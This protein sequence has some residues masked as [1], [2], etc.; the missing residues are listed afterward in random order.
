MGLAAW[1]PMMR[2]SK[3]ISLILSLILIMTALLLAACASGTSLPAASSAAPSPSVE[4]SPTAVPSVPA[5]TATTQNP[6]APTVAARATHPLAAMSLDGL[7]FQPGDLPDDVRAG[8]LDR[9]LPDWMRKL[10]KIDAAAGVALTRSGI[11]SDYG[12]AQLLFDTHPSRVADLYQRLIGF[13]AYQ[14]QGIPQPGLGDE[15]LLF[16]PQTDQSP[17]L[18]VF[19]RCRTVA[20]IQ[21]RISASEQPVIFNYAARLAQRVE[22][23][24]CRGVAQAPVLT[25]PPPL[26]TFTPS[27]RVTIAQVI[28]AQVTRLADPSGVDSIRAYAFADANHGWL[29]A[30]TGLYYTQDGGRHWTQLR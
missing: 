6:S 13:E 14:R 7:L 8:A 5:L 29:K 27:P 9:V 25:P 26:P 19:H 2:V 30:D 12:R 16:L 18:L 17:T 4:Y 21:L 24:D 28:S 10:P 11:P 22:A 23:V 15:A 3:S 20:D 1:G